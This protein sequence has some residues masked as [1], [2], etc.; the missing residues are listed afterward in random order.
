VRSPTDP[1]NTAVI[2]LTNK[3][4]IND[5]DLAFLLANQS[6]QFRRVDADQRISQSGHR[7][8]ESL[9]EFRKELAQGGIEGNLPY[10]MRDGRLEAHADDRWGW[11]VNGL[12]GNKAWAEFRSN[13]I[14]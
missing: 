1:C 11:I 7:I 6:M 13:P 14:V 5:K 10:V 9:Y 3:A 4:E 8:F 2:D 12:G